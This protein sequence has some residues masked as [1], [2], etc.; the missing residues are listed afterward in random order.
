MA[1]R[2]KSTSSL[3]R[4]LEGDQSTTQLGTEHDRLKREIDPASHQPIEDGSAVADRR[5][6]PDHIDLTTSVHRIVDPMLLTVR[7]GRCRILERPGTEGEPIGWPVVVVVMKADN[8]CTLLNRDL[9]RPCA[10]KLG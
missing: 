5:G 2:A 9:Y 8:G 3:S 7:Q 10:L 4:E 1:R 6:R